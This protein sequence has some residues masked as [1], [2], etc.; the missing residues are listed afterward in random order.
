MREQRTMK[1]IILVLLLSLGGVA[2]GAV[3]DPCFTK[4]DRSRAEMLTILSSNEPWN[5]TVR[6]DV[7]KNTHAPDASSLVMNIHPVRGSVLKDRHKIYRLMNA[8]KVYDPSSQK[9]RLL[10]DYED[11]KDSTLYWIYVHYDESTSTPEVLVAF[12]DQCLN[13]QIVVE[14]ERIVNTTIR[15]TIKVQ[16]ERIVEH[17]HYTRDT[18]VVEKYVDTKKD[19]VER[20]NTNNYFQNCAPQEDFLHDLYPWKYQRQDP[21]GATFLAAPVMEY[22][23]KGQKVGNCGD[24]HQDKVYVNPCDDCYRDKPCKRHRVNIYINIGVNL[25]FQRVAP[26]I[27]V[28]NGQRQPVWDVPMSPQY[29]PWD[30]PF[31][32]NNNNGVSQWDTPMTGG[33]TQPQPQPQYLWDIPWHK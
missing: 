15:D 8:L 33:T 14:R 23:C 30:T 24:C 10:Y 31:Y 32:F 29:V 28:Y 1:S 9:Y 5:T 4:K 16:V 26:A 27:M 22:C 3:G 2:I 21:C 17:H 19:I 25:L 13:P 7:L 6:E 11:V 20:D 12:K 18:L